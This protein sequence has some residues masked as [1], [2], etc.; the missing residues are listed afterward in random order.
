MLLDFPSAHLKLLQNLKSHYNTY[1]LSNTNESHITY[2]NNK[3]KD[4]YGLDS[5]L[6]LFDEVYYSHEVKMRKPD[7]EVFEHILKENDLIP[8]ETLFIDDSYQ[9]IE[10]A[11]TLGIRTHH[12]KKPQ[13]ITDIFPNGSTK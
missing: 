11:N 5:F 7:P 1:L 3:I 10:G 4:W 13:K 2:Y 6:P 9:H 8:D 12:L